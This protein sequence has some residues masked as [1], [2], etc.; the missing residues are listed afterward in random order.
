MV[1]MVEMAMTTNIHRF[2]EVV[3]STAK[4]EGAEQDDD[5]GDGDD[6]RIIK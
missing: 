6:V 4:G 1:A 5:N 3:E 2:G